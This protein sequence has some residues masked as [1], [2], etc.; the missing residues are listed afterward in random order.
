MAAE[1]SNAGGLRTVTGLTQKAPAN[2]AIKITR[3]HAMTDKPFGVNLILLPGFENLPYDE[4]IRAI[5][6]GCWGVELWNGH[7]V[8]T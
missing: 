3:C 4:Y 5:I 2:L 8:N 6:D 1:V 7:A